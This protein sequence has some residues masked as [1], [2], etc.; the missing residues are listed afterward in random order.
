[1]ARLARLILLPFFLLFAATGF[2]QTKDSIQHLQKTDTA[3]LDST[4]VYFFTH[5]R[6][7]TTNVRNVFHIDTVLHNTENYDPKLQCQSFSQSPG[8]IGLANRN[9]F[10]SPV[11]STGFNL[12]IRAFDNYLFSIDKIKYFSSIAPFTQL[13]YVMGSRKEQFFQV[14]HSHTIKRQ[15]VIAADFR[16]VNSRGRQYWRQK[17]DDINT[18]FTAYYTTKNERYGVFANYYYNRVKCEENGGI[19]DDTI[20]EQFREG[21]NT[22]QFGIWLKNAMNM[23]KENAYLMKHFVNLDFRKPDSIDIGKLK[24]FSLG[25]FTLTTSYRKPRF[26]YKDQDAASG[27][28][29]AIFADSVSTADSLF[30]QRLDNTLIWT[31]NSV[32]AHGEASKFRFYAGF[33][34]AYIEVHEEDQTSFLNQYTSSAGFS[35][36]LF[37]KLFLSASAEYV[38]G[39]Y[40]IGDLKGDGFLSYRFGKEKYRGTLAI[41]AT[42]ARMEAPWIASHFYSNYFRWINI[43]S[44]Q[45]VVAWTLKYSYPRLETGLNWY[46]VNNLIYW[47][48]FALPSQYTDKAINIY[49]FYVNKDFV[50]GK[51]EI[52]NKAILQISDNDIIHVPLF[53]ASQSYF[54]TLDLFKK[55]LKFQVGFDA[56][57]NTLY[58]AD[59][60]MPASRQFY[61]QD[62]R[63]IGNY[64]Y[65]DVFVNLKIKRAKIFLAWDHFN[66]GLMGYKYYSIPHY[67][68]ADRSLRFG[69]NWLFHD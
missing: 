3:S 18:Y 23:V 68:E 35:L 8:N 41:E 48:K 29:P 31:N 63:K 49:S 45:Q 21:R 66:S 19:T 13:N 47:N 1:M 15:L 69:V 46:N 16:L 4:K 57:Y 64:I 59:A 51:F 6:L 5:T 55:A 11:L 26:I 10:F 25:R 53:A 34:H 43:F 14:T 9:M 65:L 39:N 27:Y 2:A 20:Y 33:H 42:Y 36:L 58:Y 62:Q 30:V 37:K 7:D 40:N 56:R 54:V 44:K 24:G 38:I 28:Y 61:W 12:G 60:W 52:D 50:F 67:P 22:A 32:N 17:S